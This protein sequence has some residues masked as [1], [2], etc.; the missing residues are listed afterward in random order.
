MAD[1]KSGIGFP[2]DFQ[3]VG[4]EQWKGLNTKPKRAAIEDQQ[5]YWLENIMPIGEAN[6]RAMYGKGTTLY[7]APEIGRAHV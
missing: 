7:T 5:S 4:L 3:Y 2:P 6:A 1:G